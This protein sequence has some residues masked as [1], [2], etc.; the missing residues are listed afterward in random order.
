M[1]GQKCPVCQ[2]A[3][4]PGEKV[5]FQHGRLVHLACYIEVRAAKADARRVI[6]TPQPEDQKRTQQHEEC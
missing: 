6:G 5:A 1:A 3:I 4:V 2:K